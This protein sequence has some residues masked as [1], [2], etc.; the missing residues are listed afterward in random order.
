[1]E[2]ETR[3]MAFSIERYN[4]GN[5]SVLCGERKARILCTDL[6]GPK[7]IVAAV[8][9]HGEEIVVE[10]Y[11]DGRFFRTKTSPEWDLTLVDKQ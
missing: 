4:T 7:K 5:Y 9:Y 11:G 10:L 3:K 1:M 8:W 6:K 2:K